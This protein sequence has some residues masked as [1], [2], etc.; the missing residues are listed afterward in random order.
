MQGDLLAAS[1]NDNLYRVNLNGAGSINNNNDVSILGS[2]FGNNPLDV[3][4]Q[5][6]NDPFPGTI[7]IAGFGTN[8]IVVFE[9]TDFG[10]GG[11][12]PA[13]GDDIYINA[14]GVGFTANGITWNSDQNFQGGK[15]FTQNVPIAN[16]NADLLYQSERFG[17]M[18]YNIPVVNGDYEV[19][20]HFAEVWSG[21]TNPGSRVFDV[22]IEGN[23]VLNNFDIT[24]NAGFQTATVQ[25][26]NATVNDGTLNIN[27]GAE[28]QNPKISGIAVISQSSGCEGNYSNSIDEDGDG[29][30]NGL[31]EQILMVLKFLI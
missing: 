11:T 1:F 22:S 15:V 24:A 10:G 4:A 9:P 5:G 17:N 30:T 6:D 28:I 7:W 21:G 8:N 19:Q 25:T 13:N 16:T 29:F 3:T 31:M 26:F 12:N 23:L 18:S 2:G 20:L 14:G 27:F